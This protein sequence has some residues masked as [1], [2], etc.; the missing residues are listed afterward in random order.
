MPETPPLYPQMTVEGFLHFV[1]RIKGIVAGDRNR[2]VNN[3]IAHCNLEDKPKILIRKL[4]KGFRQRVGIA[5]AILHDSPAIILDEPTV[6]LAP[7]KSSMS[8]T[9]SKVSPETIQ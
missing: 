3:A 8:L 5:Q 7:V 4:S 2:R 1:A 6:G 9:R